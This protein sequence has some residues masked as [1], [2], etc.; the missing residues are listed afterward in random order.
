MVKFT[1]TEVIVRRWVVKFRGIKVTVRR[2]IVKFT[3][4]EVEKYAVKFE[5]N[6]WLF[7]KER[8]RKRR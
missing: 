8:L 7:F 4:S 6:I 3:S 1:G 2:W 5:N